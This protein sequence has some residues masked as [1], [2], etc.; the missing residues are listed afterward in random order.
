MDRF[1]R[2][3]RVKHLPAKQRLSGLADLHDDSEELE[4][5]GYKFERAISTLCSE[6][7]S[8]STLYRR[9]RSLT[10][11]QRVYEKVDKTLLVFL[12]ARWGGY[13][14]DI[15]SDYRWAEFN[16]HYRSLLTN[17]PRL[18][19]VG[20]AICERYKDNI[21]SLLNTAAKLS[22]V[23]IEDS[24]HSERPPSARACSGTSL[25]ESSED[26]P[27]NQEAQDA[28]NRPLTSSEDVLQGGGATMTALDASSAESVRSRTLDLQPPRHTPSRTATVSEGS[29]R[30]SD[31][32]VPSLQIQQSTQTAAACVGDEFGFPMGSHTQGTEAL[33]FINT[34]QEENLDQQG[35]VFLL[36]LGEEDYTRRR[37][38]GQAGNVAPG[39]N[40]DASAASMNFQSPQNQETFP[41]VKMMLILTDIVTDTVIEFSDGGFSISKIHL[42]NNGQ[43]IGTIE[44]SPVMATLVLRN[45]YFRV[46]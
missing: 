29:D 16:D 15:I 12:V 13:I 36:T 21:E 40:V 34:V 24:K 28:Q 31:L 7:R 1:I 18:P 4:R 45:I 30:S 6:V 11:F 33:S 5:L 32:H 8:R 35:T 2:G 38:E 41:L 3:G 25:Q 14:L 27:V 43:V 19:D 23:E 42:V 26:S 20:R 44:V 46:P 10:R 17:Y 39:S 22:E 37:S 9:K